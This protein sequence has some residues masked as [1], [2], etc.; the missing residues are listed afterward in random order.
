MYSHMIRLSSKITYFNTNK[1][2]SVTN[3]ACVNMAVGPEAE[4]QDSSMR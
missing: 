2:N 1:S 4:M 3:K